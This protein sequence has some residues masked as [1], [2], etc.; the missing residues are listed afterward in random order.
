MTDTSSLRF[1]EGSSWTDELR[2]EAGALTGSGDGDDGDLPGR[3]A[4]ITEFNVGRARQFEGML[5]RDGR[6]SWRTFPAKAFLIETGRQKFI[7][8]T[9]YARHFFTQAVGIYRLYRLLAPV[10][11]GSGEDLRVQMERSGT[12]ARELTALVVSHFHV[13]HIAGLADF[14]GLPVYASRAAW[15][16]I[17]GVSGVKAMRQGLIP[18]LVPAHSHGDRRVIDGLDT[19]SLPDELRPFTVGLALS[20]DRNVILVELPGHARGQIGAFVKTVDGWELI[21]SD[22]AWD[23]RAFSGDALRGPSDFMMRFQD[24]KAAYMKTLGRLQALYRN[25][26]RIRLS[27]DRR[28]GGRP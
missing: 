9:G 2:R 1:A 4:R 26:I 6:S 5:L 23:A 12:S 25:G 28:P 7:W 14:A 24:D 21:A 3:A 13:D 10:R 19:V 17:D 15:R 8:D 27:H 16:S 20:A 11:L 22:A 18:A